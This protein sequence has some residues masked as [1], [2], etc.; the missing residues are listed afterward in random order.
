MLLTDLITPERIACGIDAQSKKRALERLSEIISSTEDTISS[1]DVFESLLTRER[2]GGTGVGHGV[3][4]PHGRLKDN[5]L[6]LG[7][8]IKL[9]TGVDYDAADRQP[10]DLLFALLVPKESTDEHL[11]V[12]AQLAKIFSNEDFRKQL[13]D[14]NSSDEIYQ[15]LLSWNRYK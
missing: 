12:L 1:N 8:F 9:Q 2:L 11:Q 3:A 6:T 14:A 10:V 5:S 7:A 13:R 15:L 4:I